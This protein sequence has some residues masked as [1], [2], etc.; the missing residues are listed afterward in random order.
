MA[1]VIELNQS[2]FQTKVTAMEQAGKNITT[3]VS[4]PELTGE[5]PA[6]E[7]YIQT[8]GRLQEALN[9]YKALIEEDVQRLKGAQTSMTFAE[10]QIIKK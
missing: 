2:G 5:M 6:L 7:K 1:N 10:S 9:E 8:Y 4:M 3:K